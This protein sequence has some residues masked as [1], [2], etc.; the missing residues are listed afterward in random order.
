MKLGELIQELLRLHQY[1]QFRDDIEVKATF[2]AGFG[3]GAVDYVKWSDTKGV[4][5]IEI[6]N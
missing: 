4:V 5:I 1:Q 6:D 3:E 2:D